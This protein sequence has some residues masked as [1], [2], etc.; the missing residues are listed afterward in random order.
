MTWGD[1]LAALETARMA[2][3]LV[4][5]AEAQARHYKGVAEKWKAHAEQLQADLEKVWDLYNKKIE[6]YNK[7]TAAEVAQAALKEAALSEIEKL[8]PLNKMLNTGYRK[9]LYEEAYGKTLADR[10]KN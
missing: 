2:G 5:E 7:K 4:G 6:Q 8:D 1:N 3:Q 10:Q 9:K